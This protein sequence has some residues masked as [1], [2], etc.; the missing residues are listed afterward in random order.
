[1]RQVLLIVC[2]VVA[3]VLLSQLLFDFY[4][5]NRSQACATGGGR[6]CGGAP[7]AINR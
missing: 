1:V 7:T 5:W 3:A 4:Q 2:A 6:N